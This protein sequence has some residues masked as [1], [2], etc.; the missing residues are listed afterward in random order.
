M[1]A[2]AAI[3]EV[4]SRGGYRRTVFTLAT[5]W[6]W[7]AMGVS[8]CVLP[9]LGLWVGVERRYNGESGYCRGLG[10]GRGG[11]GLMLLFTVLILILG[12]D[13]GRAGWV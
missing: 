11:R 12:W 13:H 2:C 7:R 1:M 6:V 9:M 10:V 8:T 5:G 4:C 3:L